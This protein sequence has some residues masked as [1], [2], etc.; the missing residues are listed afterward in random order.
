MP[1]VKPNW[2]YMP[3][4]GGIPI[5]T[6]GGAGG[7]PHGGPPLGGPNGPRWIS[8]FPPYG[9][10]GSDGP[11]GHGGFPPNSPPPSGFIRSVGLPPRGPGGSGGP[12]APG[13]PNGP[14]PR[15]QPPVGGFSGTYSSQQPVY[16]STY[17]PTGNY[18]TYQYY[19]Y[20]EPNR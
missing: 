16:Q 14:D 11:G 10:N 6:T 8:G 12:G 17:N 9:P 19:Q 1:W 18:M 4:M 20:V 3:A 5:H 7:P 2:S 13:G 15:N